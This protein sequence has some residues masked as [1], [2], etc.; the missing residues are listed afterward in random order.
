MLVLFINILGALFLMFLRI[1][2][3]LLDTI[4]KKLTELTIMGDF[5]IHLMDIRSS[6]SLDFLSSMLAAGTYRLY[7]SPLS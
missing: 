6:V 1:L 7:V 4:L 5:N 2:N 3:N